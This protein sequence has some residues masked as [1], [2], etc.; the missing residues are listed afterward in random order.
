MVH[1]SGGP[2]YARSYKLQKFT[3]QM[4]PDAKPHILFVG[5]Y[6]LACH[7]PGYRNV[8]AFLVPCFESQ[9]AYL[10]AKQLAPVIGGLLVEVEYDRKGLVALTT[11]WQIYH[12]P[13]E[14]DW[15]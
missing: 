14:K 4:P 3:E 9:T 10:R 12:T 1:P 5:H 13:L 15:P 11:K 8:E 2:S 7:L 6:H